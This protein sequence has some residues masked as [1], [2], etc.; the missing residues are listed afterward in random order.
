MLASTNKGLRF[1]LLLIALFVIISALLLSG[2]HFF[3]Y[4]LIGLSVLVSS[5]WLINSFRPSSFGSIPLFG[6]IFSVP[7]AIIPVAFA[8]K[9]SAIKSGAFWL[10]IGLIL[11]IMAIAVLF[12]LVLTSQKHL[13]YLKNVAVRLVPVTVIAII[14][15]FTPSIR[16]IEMV[17]RS[18]PE[19]IEELNSELL[20]P[21]KTKTKKQ[22]IAFVSDRAGNTDI[23]EINTDGSGL[24]PLLNSSNSEWSPR[25]TKDGTSLYYLMENESGTALY[26]LNL[27]DGE[28]VFVQNVPEGDFYFNLHP[29]E[30]SIVCHDSVDGYLQIF[31]RSIVDSTVKQLTFGDYNNAKPS[32]FSDGNRVLFQSDRNGNWDIFIYDLI[33][34]TA[35]SVVNNPE[36]E[37]N[38]VVS[39]YDDV[40]VYNSQSQPENGKDLYY[41]DI[42]SKET[43][44]LSNS[45]GMEISAVFSSN[46]QELVFSSN[47]D[48]NWEIYLMSNRGEF[49]DRLTNHP[50]FDGDAIWINR[51]WMKK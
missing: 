14:L 21:Y 27:Q 9:L 34:D 45:P 39:P 15:Y 17:Y 50:S 25:I 43:G 42:I 8:L 47:R 6:I 30:K 29:D 24:R 7:M 1:E 40:I 19:K 44:R 51:G 22:S 23:L 38:P 18:D 49:K 32:F 31:L 20:Y 4:V 12:V 41:I 2:F 26:K 3:S 35:Y 36:N 46:A 48:G 13:K 5:L 33:N 16:I 11:S 28:N 10:F 37:E